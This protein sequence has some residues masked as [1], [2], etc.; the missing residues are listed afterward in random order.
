M[1]KTASNLKYATETQMAFIFSSKKKM[2]LEILLGPISY[3]VKCI[4]A[5]NY[6]MTIYSTNT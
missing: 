2:Y 5:I 4:K 3:A 6:I 1:S